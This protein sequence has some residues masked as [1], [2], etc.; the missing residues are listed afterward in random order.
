[1]N[2]SPRVLMRVLGG[3]SAILIALLVYP[4]GR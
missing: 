3:T 2:R 4:E 1:M